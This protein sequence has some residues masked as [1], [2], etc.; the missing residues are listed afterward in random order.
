MAR[1]PASSGARHPSRLLISLLICKMGLPVV[2]LGQV[3]EGSLSW[4]RRKV[5]RAHGNPQP[6]LPSLQAAKTP[7]A[8]Q[9]GGTL[10]KGPLQQL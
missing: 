4:C 6:G 2:S 5:Q 8:P 7:R 10:R 3:L 9:C 1:A